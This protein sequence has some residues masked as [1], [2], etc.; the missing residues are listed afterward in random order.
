MYIVDNDVSGEVLV[1]INDKNPIYMY[2]YIFLF[3]ILAAALVSSMLKCCLDG[4][5]RVKIYNFDVE[6]VSARV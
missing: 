5:Q 2:F 1:F 6:V 4:W 3:P